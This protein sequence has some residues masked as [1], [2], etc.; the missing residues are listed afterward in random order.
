MLSGVL[1]SFDA[2]LRPG[3]WGALTADLVALPAM[4]I[5]G[6]SKH[7]ILTILNGKNRRV[8]GRIQ[9]AILECPTAV[10][11]LG[12]LSKGMAS[13]VRFAPGGTGKF[14]ELFHEAARG[15]G[16]ADLCL[17]PGGLRAGGATYKFANEILDIG[18]LKF[19]G[20]WA[21]MHT[22]EHYI[23]EATATLVMMHAGRTEIEFLEAFVRSGA[24]FLKPPDLPWACYF[25]RR[26][27]ANG[28]ASNGRR[29]PGGRSR[30]V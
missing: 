17:T 27:Q 30:V 26:R 7:A 28:F 10:A 13:G 24:V 23:Q 12:W 14:R 18:R 6:L 5:Q 16:I 21:A 9:V 3:D 1:V 11:W 2:L 22:L 19:R 15:L 20:R 4:G 8:F 29:H 25:S